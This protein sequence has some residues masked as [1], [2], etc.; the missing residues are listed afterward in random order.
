MA[1]HLFSKRVQILFVPT[2]TER[3]VQPLYHS[4]KFKLLTDLMTRPIL[5]AE[6]KVDVVRYRKCSWDSEDPSRANHTLRSASSIACSM[7]SAPLEYFYNMRS[8][9]AIMLRFVYKNMRKEL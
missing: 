7:P 3:W 5:N 8:T 2:S 6:L 4:Y 9:S 1:S